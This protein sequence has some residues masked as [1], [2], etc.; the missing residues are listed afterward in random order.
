MISADIKLETRKAIYARDGYRCA[1]C[2]STKYIQ[3]HHFIPRGH[4]GSD[5]PHN[6]ICLC[7][8]CHGTAHGMQLYGPDIGVYDIEKDACEYLADFY[9]PD[10]NPW[11]KG[12]NIY[13]NTGEREGG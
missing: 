11:K 8:D 1:L 10:W 3:I 6:L 9:A 5:H 12:Y 13:R 4:G 7:S 2:D